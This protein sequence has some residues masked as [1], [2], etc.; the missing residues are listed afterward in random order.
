MMYDVEHF[1]IC[2]L[3]ICISYLVRSMLRSF[4][5]FLIR[6]F[7]FLLLSFKSPLYILDNSPLS[8]ASFANIFPQA[9]LLILLKEVF[10]FNEV[11]L[12]NSFFHGS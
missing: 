5:Y 2:L 6:L 11:Q 10:N 8:D 4:A 3:A 12:I 9:C 1:F 7:V